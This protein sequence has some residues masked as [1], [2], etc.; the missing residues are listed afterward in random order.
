MTEKRRGALHPL[1]IRTFGDIAALGLEVHVYCTSC[2]SWRRVDLQ[3]E[4][5]RSRCVAG[6]RFTCQATR[7]DGSTCGGFGHPSIRT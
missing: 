3:A 5:L 1:P 4:R 7:F 2:H 6:A